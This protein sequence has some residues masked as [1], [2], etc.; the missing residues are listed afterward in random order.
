MNS[1]SAIL[2]APQSSRPLF[3][4]ISAALTAALLLPFL[5]SSRHKRAY[6]ERNTGLVFIQVPPPRKQPLTQIAVAKPRT[7]PSAPGRP[8]QPLVSVQR[9]PPEMALD[10]APIAAAALVDLPEGPA[11]APLRMDPTVLRHANQASKSDVRKLAESS[12]AY[13]G[14]SPQS[15]DEQLAQGIASA[16]KPDCLRPGGS[17]L[18]VFVV[19]YQVIKDKCK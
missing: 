5:Q 9:V 8:L 13:I 6:Q 18:D 3:L 10:P 11:S 16:G 4:L 17:L 7:R 12:G 1:A 15:K 2:Q 19:A 14:T